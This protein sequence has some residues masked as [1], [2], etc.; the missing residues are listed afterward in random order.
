VEEKRKGGG[1]ERESR[2]RL[3]QPKRRERVRSIQKGGREC[4]MKRHRYAHTRARTRTARTHK[5]ACTH[6]HACLSRAPTH[7]RARAHT[8]REHWVE[9][10]RGVG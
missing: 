1:G 2:V 10:T 4:A 6:K 5:C 9:E 3:I 8:R 7:T